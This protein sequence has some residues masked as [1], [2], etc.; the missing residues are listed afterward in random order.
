[1]RTNGGERRSR[2]DVNL[3]SMVMLLCGRHPIPS[4]LGLRRFES[5]FMIGKSLARKVKQ[6]GEATFKA[7]HLLR[8]WSFLCFV[9][10]RHQPVDQQQ[11]FVHLHLLAIIFQHLAKGLNEPGATY[12]VPSRDEAWCGGER[13]EEVRCSWD[14]DG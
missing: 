6:F 14:S 3:C 11:N 9:A 7:W 4:Y 13:H 1:M 2:L 12:V 8:C 10:S 5:I